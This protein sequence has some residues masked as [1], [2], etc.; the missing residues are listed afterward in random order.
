MNKSIKKFFMKAIGNKILK[1]EKVS[2]QISLESSIQGVGK[3][4]KKMDLED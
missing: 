3:K 2:K 1:W 4:V